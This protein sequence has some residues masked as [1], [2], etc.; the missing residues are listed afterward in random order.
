MSGLSRRKLIT[1]GL[2]ATAGVAGLAMSPSFTSAVPAAA[3]LLGGR[4]SA[5]TLHFVITLLLV[6]FFVVHVAM[7]ALAGFWKRTRAM[8]TGRAGAAKEDA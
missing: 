3:S 7:I 8:V 6:G 5:R 1:G 4:Q 2:A